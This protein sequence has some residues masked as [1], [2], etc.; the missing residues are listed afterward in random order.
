MFI[1]TAHFPYWMGIEGNALD[2]HYDRSTNMPHILY[3]FT[4]QCADAG[5]ANPKFCPFA[6]ASLQSPD[7]R[8]DILNRIN[9]IIGNLTQKS[10]SVST[11]WWANGTYTFSDFVLSLPSLLSSTSS[12][13]MAAK[14]LL[15]LETV[16]QQTNTPPSH[17]TFKR[18]EVT[19]NDSLAFSSF[20]RDSLISGSNSIF[21]YPAVFC[22]DSNFNNIGSVDEFVQYISTQIDEN[23]IIGYSDVNVAMCLAWPNLTAYDIERYRSPSPAI[24]NNKLLVI[25]RVYGVEFSYSGA[26]ATYEYLGPDNANFITNAGYGDDPNDCIDEAIKGYFVEGELLV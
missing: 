25:G 23:P 20:N 6:S 26:L 3:A 16:I 22:L 4:A 8:K 24:L 5:T 7:P 18:S 12:W 2:Y 14:M 13:C 17:R 21:A 11:T 1:A 10:Y 19:T 9:Y 15:Q